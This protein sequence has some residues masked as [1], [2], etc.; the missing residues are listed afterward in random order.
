[1]N[2]TRF[3][4]AAPHHAITRFGRGRYD[5]PF[6][7][8]RRATPDR[9]EVDLAA[10]LAREDE[11]SRVRRRGESVAPSR[12]W[13]RRAR[14]PRRT[15]EDEDGIDRLLRRADT[16][17]DEHPTVRDAHRGVSVARFREART[18]APA[19]EAHVEDL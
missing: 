12:P 15:R 5:G 9:V 18:R 4:D 10:R 16:T 13:H 6:S 3:V 2:A 14:G 11:E 19:T 7:V 17:D 1:P 8:R